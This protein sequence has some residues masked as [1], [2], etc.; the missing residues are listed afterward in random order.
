MLKMKIHELF[1]KVFNN[2]VLDIAAITFLYEFIIAG[3]YYWLYCYN[4]GI[5]EKNKIIISNTVSIRR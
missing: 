2:I 4:K 3:Y 5:E 1:C